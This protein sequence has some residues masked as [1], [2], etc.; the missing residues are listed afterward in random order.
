MCGP[1]SGPQ[2]GKI[3]STV[4]RDQGYAKQLIKF[5]YPNYVVDDGNV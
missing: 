3:N 4:E 1:L 5:K 2:R